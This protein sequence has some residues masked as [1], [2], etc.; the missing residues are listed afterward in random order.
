MTEDLVNPHTTQVDDLQLIALP[1]AVNCADLFVR[2]SLTEWSLAEMRDEAIKVTAA[3]VTNV[4]ETTDSR[5]PG[6]LTVRL[7]LRGDALVIEVEDQNPAAP[8]LVRLVGS[9]P[10]GVARGT[11]GA[12][13]VWCELPL[14]GGQK[15]SAVPLPRRER[16]R[17]PAAEA[18]A[19]EPAEVDPQ[20]MERVLYAL[21][22]APEKDPRDLR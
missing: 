12:K 9:R 2:F 15:A 16:R 18:L 11:D 19:N 8:D 13:L 7:R 4:V 10:S 3:L 20:V 14:P 1:S 21:N 6:M 22:H 5:S 17:S